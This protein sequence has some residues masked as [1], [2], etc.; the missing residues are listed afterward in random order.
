MSKV[1]VWA[2]YLPQFH[3]T[4]ENNKWWGEG[5]TEWTNVTKAKPL[6]K[7]HYQPRYPS[8]L[9][10]YDLR[11]PEVRARQ[12]E[13]AQEYGIEGF[14]YYHYWFGNGQRMLQRPFE[15]VLQSAHPDFPF[16]LCWA[17][18][19]WTAIWHGA[20]T[21]DM[22]MKQEYL[23]KESYEAHFDYLLKA[24]RDPRYITVDGKP[25]F[26][27]L[28][29][30]EIP[31]LDV[32]T[33][34]LRRCAENAGLNGL[35]LL[36]GYVPENWIPGDHNFD[37]VIGTEFSTLRFYTASRYEKKS[38]LEK[39]LHRAKAK[40]TGGDNLDIKKRKKPII[41]EYETAIKY[42]VSPPQQKNIDYYPCAIPN[43]DNSA[44]VGNKGIVFH[45]ST[46][47]IWRKHLEDALDVIKE[48]PDEK[49]ILTIKSWNEWA[50]GNYLEP[51]KVWGRQ[52]LQVLKETLDKQ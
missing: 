16:C 51:D 50:E 47:Q 45:N 11:V 34:T 49:K 22:L 38:L 33:A 2:Y 17:N 7:G 10:Y 8:D 1:R 20:K 21:A 24:F 39:V 35:Y 46:P 3:P 41:V 31:D 52:Y 23:G 36:A 40:L 14:I 18:Q 26:Q 12:A 9:G 48:R 5:F 30:M 32:L 19:S 13:L 4:P 15:E 27:I 43:W 37:G 28:A 29:P 44:R 25:V 42:L 6:F